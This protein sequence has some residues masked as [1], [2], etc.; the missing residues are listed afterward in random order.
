MSTD[1]VFL[2]PAQLVQ[3]WNNSIALQTLSNWR[4]KKQGP[5]FQKL[6]SRVLYPLDKVIEWEQANQVAVNDNSK[7]VKHG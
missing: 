5:D 6:G 3:R 4:H 2:T 1:K 7:A